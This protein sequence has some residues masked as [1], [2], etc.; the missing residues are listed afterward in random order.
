MTAI[1]RIRIG[2]A[3]PICWYLR[4]APAQRGRGFLLFRVLPAILPPPPASFQAVRPD[5]SRIRL[6]Y[7]EVLGLV[8]FAQ[9]G[10]EEPEGRLLA[11]LARAGTTAFDVG[12]NVG[13]HTIPLARAMPSGT[14]IA[15]EPLPAN[16]RRL[17]ENAAD[18]GVANVELAQAAVGAAEGEIVLQLADDPAFA[19]TTAVH[20]RRKAVDAIR[21]PL[22]TIDRLWEEAGR[23]GVSVV[24]IDIE[25][26]E[27]AALL[28]A[29]T[30]LD[31][32]HPPL[33][34]ETQDA[35]RP[36]VSEL[37]A[38]HGYAPRAADGLEPWNV[39][40]VHSA[41]PGQPPA[42]ANAS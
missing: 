1:D 24:K 28:G 38:E 29:T 33:L 12:A 18:N 15:V 36:L 35:A 11:S 37:L 27:L 30:M 19:S 10:F 40:F 9:G 14:V 32:E 22:T 31:A 23:P 16:A 8:T 7:R 39:L 20:V 3:R 41:T 25:G 26:G 4:H 6:T 2:L 34:I 13:I 5:G 21:V 17:R 42:G